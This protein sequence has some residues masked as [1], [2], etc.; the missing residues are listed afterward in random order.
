MNCVYSN[1]YLRT[2]YERSKA[3]VSKMNFETKNPPAINQ[4]NL[5]MLDK[6]GSSTEFDFKPAATKSK[7]HDLERLLQQ[8]D[9][10][11]CY[12][13]EY[14]LI[15]I[16]VVDSEEIVGKASPIINFGDPHLLGAK[17]EDYETLFNALMEIKTGNIT[18]MN[19]FST[20]NLR[21]VPPYQTIGDKKVAVRKLRDSMYQV[22]PFFLVE[23]N[24]SHKVG[25]KIEKTADDLNALEG[26]NIYA[27]FNM[28]G[29][30]IED[31]NKQ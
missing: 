26:F 4:S 30:L 27:A 13:I 29:F 31:V 7:A 20:S 10:F 28:H 9:D 22:E 14:G 8:K 18:R 25:V 2:A 24:K 1:E 17:A 3:S 6:V 16:P 19:N 11:I 12:G 21:Y 23:G 15:I 5:L